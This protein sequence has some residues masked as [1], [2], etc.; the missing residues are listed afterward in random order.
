M[1]T[2]DAVQM[3]SALAQD[4]RLEV[5]RYLVKRG[6]EGACAGDIAEACAVQ[7]STL[8]HHLNLM[9]NADL[10]LRRRD[11]RQMIYSVNFAVV[12]GL[13][14][15]LWEECCDGQPELCLPTIEGKCR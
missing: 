12:S 13:L 5:F 11:Q 2:I 9:R 6:P 1:E 14:G 7:P 15:Y 3:L 10:I 4:A 8:S